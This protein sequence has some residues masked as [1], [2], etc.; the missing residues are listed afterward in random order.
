MSSTALARTIVTTLVAQGVRH[1]VLAPGSR[2]APL[3]L[4]LSVAEKQDLLTLHVRVDERGAGFEALGLSLG[5][6]DPVAVVTTSGTAV[7]NLL[8]AVMEARHAAVPLIVVSA[9]RPASMINSGASQTTNQLGLFTGHALDITRMSTESG[10]QNSWRHAIRRAVAIAVGTRTRQP[11]PVQLNVEFS[12]PLVS[13]L[14]LDPFQ[15]QPTVTVQASRPA[16]PYALSQ[17]RRTVVLAGDVS[18]PEVGD[19][20]VEFAEGAGLPLLAEPSSNA[21]RGRNAISTYRLLL[22][23]FAE[24]IERVVVFGHP[25]LSRPVTDLLSRQDCELVVVADQAEW[26]DPGHAAT[27]VV[28]DVTCAPGDPEWLAAWQEADR[29]MTERLDADLTMIN[30]RMSPRA[31][32]RALWDA[33]G[34]QDVVVLGSSNPARDADLAP[35][36]KGMPRVF[37]NRGLAG[38]DGTI[39]TA[40]GIC[41]GLGRPV[42]AIMGDL[43]FMHDIGSLVKGSKEQAVDLRVVV[44]DDRGGSIFQGLE[45]GAI[46]YSDH[47]E[48]VF[49][50]PQDFDVAKAAEGLGARVV[51]TAEPTS[52]SAALAKP[53]EGLEVVVVPIDRTSRP[54]PEVGP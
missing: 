47:F 24:R 20:A 28:D 41:E 38:I 43:T 11:G 18:R 13:Q 49:A 10:D 9:D 44:L 50:T 53:V 36:G 45:Q 2:N 42:T 23:E 52:L 48:R 54:R 25:T 5:T 35:V 3:S 51:T 1:V 46:A 14:L 17:G 22:A 15:T 16:V 8:P 6:G 12:V 33:L 37:S 26:R 40:R 7:G 29:R 19:R 39:A 4:A 27:L 32:A 34:E 30:G 21:R 31:A